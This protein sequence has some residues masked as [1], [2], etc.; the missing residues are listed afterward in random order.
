MHKYESI[1][2]VIDGFVIKEWQNTKNKKVIQQLNLKCRS[3]Q[4]QRNC[5]RAHLLSQFQDNK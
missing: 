2:T 4:K 3:S 5:L 1:L